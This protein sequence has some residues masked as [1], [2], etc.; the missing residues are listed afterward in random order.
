VQNQVESVDETVLAVESR[1]VEAAVE[2]SDPGKE[3]QFGLARREIMEPNTFDKSF[4]F[5]FFVFKTFTIL[6]ICIFSR[7]ILQK[8]FLVEE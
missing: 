7:K 3:K 4:L 2:V 5:T 1:A 6:Q 8:W